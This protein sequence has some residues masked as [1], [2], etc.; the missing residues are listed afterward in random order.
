MDPTQTPQS[1]PN[2]LVTLTNKKTKEV[3]RVK[4][5][6]LP[7]YGLPTTYQAP[8]DIYAKSVISGN[9][10]GEIPADSKAAAQAVLNESGYNGDKSAKQKDADIARSDALDRANRVI[11][12]LDQKDKG[13]KAYSDALNAA[14]SNYTS[15]KA[16]G[17]GGKNLT[18]TELSVLAGATPVIKKH[19]GNIFEKAA[20]FLTGDEVP[21]RGEVADDEETIR[22][23]MNN[24]ITVLKSDNA[25]KGTTGAVPAGAMPAIA[26]DSATPQ[27]P[28]TAPVTPKKADNP[29]Q[30]GILKAATDTLPI[31]GGT[32]GAI[33]GG[34]IGGLLGIPSG[35]GAVATGVVGAATVGGMGAAA[36][37]GVRQ[38][39]QDDP[40]G[41][42]AV[43]E[44]A[45]GAVAGT[46]GEVLNA[47][48]RPVFNLATKLPVIGPLA[49]A[50]GNVGEKAL[51]KIFGVGSERTAGEGGTKVLE[52]VKR[53]GINTGSG[54]PDELMK[55][56][57]SAQGKMGDEYSKIFNKAAE[58]GKFGQNGKIA[59][60]F[61]DAV[62]K[63][64]NPQDIAIKTKMANEAVNII[65]KDSGIQDATSAESE[66]IL[67][68]LQGDPKF[69]IHPAVVNKIK[70]RFQDIAFNELPDKSPEQVAFKKA[71][72][73]LKNYTEDLA[74]SAGD[75]KT[76]NAD[77]Q[78]SRDIVDHLQ[79]IRKSSA[80]MGGQTG[81]N[82]SL[83]PFNKLNNVAGQQGI[84]QADAAAKFSV[85]NVMPQIVT[86]DQQKRAEAAD[87]AQMR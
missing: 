38:M 45:L 74:G 71:A 52:T 43:A 31:I 48:S 55:S 60:F 83:N 21:T 40:N 16:F 32:I 78:N 41:E 86:R 46:G 17:E 37:E 80:N 51:S 15:A 18:G 35:P 54:N 6:D 3:R 44:G 11:S 2:E 34:G 67:K 20:A 4:R 79:Q 64:S 59:G 23:K 10:Q 26:S 19:T 57:L 62:G 22:N 73:L 25:R 70:Q 33:A 77:Y 68:G 53:W 7:S 47:A 29:F 76:L 9:M 49:E 12:V 69:Q 58:Q 63:S 81:I 66:N 75:I 13:T 72:S 24:A 56:A 27:K 42:K 50:A 36:G 84:S 30:H 85:K 82:T 87:S 1:D 65:L 14:V 8:A 5:A 28:D 61:T 39:L